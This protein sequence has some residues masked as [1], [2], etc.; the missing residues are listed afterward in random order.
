MSLKNK[1]DFKA[2]IL[3]GG[4]ATRLYPI[5]LDVSKPLLKI[6]NRAIIDFAIQQLNKVSGL[7]EII[8]VT[9]DKFYSDYHRWKNKLKIKARVTIVND[10][11]RTEKSKLGAV[12]D[13]YFGVRKRKINEDLLIIAGDNIFEKWLLGFVKFAQDKSP[14]ASIGIYNLKD[15]LKARRYGVVKTDRNHQILD[16]QEKPKHP[17]SAYVATCVY[18]FPKETL[19]FLRDYVNKLKRNTDRAGDYIKWLMTKVKIYGFR[20][21]SLW[22]DIGQ[23]DTYKKAQRYFSRRK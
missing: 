8:V 18:Y 5:T 2:L 7:K 9:N 16:F 3:A 15:K 20:F 14:D 12:G 22:L 11:T 19:V 13:I 4:Y 10:G 1:R 17:A 21:K 23:I 6:D